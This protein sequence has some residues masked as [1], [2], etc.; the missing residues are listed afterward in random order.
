MRIVCWNVAGLRGSFKKGAMDWICGRS[1]DVICIQETKATQEEATKVM[2]QW[3]REQY[4]F[5]FWNSCNGE[6][7][8]LGFQ[9]KGFN[10]TCIWSRKPSIQLEKPEFDKEGRTTTVDFGAFLLV[11]VYTPNSQSAESKRFRYR[12][13]KWDINIRE[14]VDALNKIKPVIICGD[15]NVAHKDVDVYKPDEFKNMV[16]GFMDEER[17]N[18]SKL[19]HLGF[20]DCFRHFQ[21][22]DTDAYT[23]WDQTR[24]FLRRSNRGWRIDYFLVSVLLQ[25]RVKECKHLPEITGSDHC[26]IILEIDDDTFNDENNQKQNQKQNQKR[27]IKLRIVES[28]GNISK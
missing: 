23:F 21:P 18:M 6:F 9:K 26:P 4:P 17:D 5:Q 28:F 11:T 24:P 7:Q 27:K 10:G 1:Y 14:Y 13:H 15:F 25:D 12:I 19:L 16:C 20:I 3:I 2:P 22:D 8:H